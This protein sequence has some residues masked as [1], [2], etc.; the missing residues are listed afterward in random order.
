LSG[1][2]SV[3]RPNESSMQKNHHSLSRK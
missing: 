3:Q 1:N 2:R